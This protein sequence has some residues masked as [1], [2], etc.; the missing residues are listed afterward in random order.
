MHEVR[1]MDLERSANRVRHQFLLP[2]IARHGAVHLEDRRSGTHGH[3]GAHAARATAQGRGFQGVDT[4]LFQC[5]FGCDFRKGVHVRKRR[6]N[7]QPSLAV[8]LAELIADLP[9]VGLLARGVE[10][11]AAS[12][13][14]G[15]HCSQAEF[16]EGADGVA[17]DLGTLE[18]LD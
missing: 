16:G 15:F 12:L 3:P 6:G 1:R 18:R 2:E 7:Q 10:V 17:D 9:H 5:E 11:V 13:E 14:C 4:R 8:E